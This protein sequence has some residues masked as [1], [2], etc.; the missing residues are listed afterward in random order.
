MTI[1]TMDRIPDDN[2]LYL[3]ADA[4]TA[5]EVSRCKP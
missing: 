5:L 3:Y 2:L 1:G 4:L